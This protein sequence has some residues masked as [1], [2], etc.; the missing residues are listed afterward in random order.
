MKILKLLMLI[1]MVS[2][3]SCG[4]TVYVFLRYVKPDTSIVNASTG[5]AFQNQAVAM[6]N[7]E[8][9]RLQTIAYSGN[10]S[11]GVMLK[12]NVHKVRPA[13]RVDYDRLYGDINHM[14]DILTKF[15]DILNRQIKMIK[16]KASENSN[17]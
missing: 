9:G 16:E 2:V 6:K 12:N 13:H 3:V 17:S 1:V 11:Q 14:G 5:F 15:N 7:I 8:D 4:T 10:D